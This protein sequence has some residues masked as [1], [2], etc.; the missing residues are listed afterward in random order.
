MKYMILSIDITIGEHRL[1]L[2]N[3]YVPNKDDVNFYNELLQKV[4][5]L[6]NDHRIF[7]GDFNVILDLDKDGKGGSKATHFKSQ[8]TLLR[9]LDE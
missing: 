6:P 9:L 4:E 5:Q 1:S 3:V 2:I 7:G 8:E